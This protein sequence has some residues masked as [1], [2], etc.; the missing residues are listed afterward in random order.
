V[1]RTRRIVLA[2]LAV[3]FFALAAATLAAGGP[4]YIPVGWV[5]CGIVLLLAVRKTGGLGPDRPGR[6]SRQGPAG[7]SDDPAKRARRSG[8]PAIRAGV[9]PPKQP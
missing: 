6:Q 1:S 9:E 8:N 7:A 3:L 2:V 5:V 4:W